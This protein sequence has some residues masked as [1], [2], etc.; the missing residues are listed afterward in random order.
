MRIVGR[1]GGGFLRRWLALIFVIFCSMMVVVYETS[2]SDK[3]FFLPEPLGGV[4]IVL[5][6]GHGGQ[7]GGA[8]RGDIIEKDITLSITKK[9][10]RQLTRLGAEV[11]LTRSTDGDVLSEHAPNEQFPTN[12][13][14]KKQDIFLREELVKQHNPDLFISI[15]ANA[16]PNSKW[17]GAQVFYHKD[18]HPNSEYLAKA[19]QQMIRD[20]VQNTDR[21]ALSI[22]EVYLLKKV[23]IPAVLVETGFLS[24]DEERELLATESYQ[25]KI[26]FAIARGIENFINVKIE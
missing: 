26:A 14:R 11:V 17:R 21:E 19:I 7:D 18:G 16:I 1:K 6:A 4:K 23:E 9:V 12:R 10:T 15:H 13:E 8:S 20:T 3:R 24:N 2:A 22:K 25:E 5:D